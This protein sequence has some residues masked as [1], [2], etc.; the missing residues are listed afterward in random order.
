MFESDRVAYLIEQFLRT[1][2]HELLLSEHFCN[3]ETTS[4]YAA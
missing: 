3:V 1:A 2:F 4:S